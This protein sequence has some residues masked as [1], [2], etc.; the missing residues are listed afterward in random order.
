[1][2]LLL[3][4]DLHLD[5]PF[6]WATPAVARKRRQHLRD[7][8]VRIVR[9]AVDQQA[10]ALLCGGDLFEQDRV[11]ADTGEFLRGTF[12]GIDPIRVVLAPGNH[13]WLG[14]TGLYAQ[15]SWPENVHLFTESRFTPLELGDGVTLWGAAHRTSSGT[16]DLLEGFRADRGGLNLALFHGSEL[17]GLARQLEGKQPHA[18]FSSAEIVGAGLSHACLGHYHAPQDADLFTYPGNPDPLSF[19]ETG[20]RGAVL[21]APGADGSM[22]RARHT[23]A[24]SEVHDVTVDLTGCPGRQAVRD[25]VAAALEGLG[26]DVRLTVGGDLAPEVV[27]DRH[28][29]DGLGGQ[30]DGLVVR[31]ASLRPGYDLDAIARE[32]TVRGQ[33]V[34]DV[35]GAA[36]PDE[37]RRRVIVTGLRALEGREDLEVE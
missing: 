30:L 36:V 27:F 26:G 5:S 1:M 14:S 28:D 31:V 29:L 4:S 16:P 37:E 6:V 24:V 25:M 20:P 2:R 3:F 13:D 17:S 21:L 11:A 9:L 15:T 23:V 8:L 34:R 22:N 35:Q 19:G 12:A 32:P 10:D 33:F 7:V 18:P